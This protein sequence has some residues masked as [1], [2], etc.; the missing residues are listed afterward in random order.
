LEVGLVAEFLAEEQSRPVMTWEV[1]SIRADATHSNSVQ[2]NKAHVVE[3]SSLFE[4]LPFENLDDTVYT[5]C[6]A[7]LKPVLDGLVDDCPTHRRL[8]FTTWPDI[9]KVPDTC[10]S[11]E[12]RAMILKQIASVG[13]CTWVGLG[14]WHGAV[15]GR[16]SLE[17]DPLDVKDEDTMSVDA[18]DASSVYTHLRVFLFCTDQGSDQ[19]ACHNM[20]L[21]DLRPCL[22]L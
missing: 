16:N 3:V 17:T 18:V 10:T 14:C 2:Q 11:L 12:V 5:R 20:I 9:Q 19:V 15:V 13:V 21:D 7:D 8:V 1:H 6:P 4:L 22:Q